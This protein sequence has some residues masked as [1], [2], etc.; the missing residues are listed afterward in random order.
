MFLEVTDA[1][2]SSHGRKYLQVLDSRIIC[3][4]PV[5]GA[6]HQGIQILPK[7]DLQVSAQSRSDVVEQ[8]SIDSDIHIHIQAQA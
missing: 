8:V 4:Q 1:L 5:A 7:F 2:S 3:H 6:N